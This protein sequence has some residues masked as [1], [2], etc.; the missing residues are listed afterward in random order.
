MS[1]TKTNSAKSLGILLIVCG[2]IGIILWLAAFIL[3]TLLSMNSSPYSEQSI[4]FP[5]VIVLAMGLLSAI[6]TLI[7][8]IRA[9][10]N[11]SVSK[12]KQIFLA[13]IALVLCLPGSAVL[14]LLQWVYV[15]V[16]A[17]LIG[18]VP[19]ALYLLRIYKE[20]K[21]HG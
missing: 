13:V 19:Q 12:R 5:A 15:Y 16:P 11:T 17:L 3:G 18:L 9:V 1:S 6:L 7:I 10:K 14:I 21:T 8:G 2:A 20:E 4:Y